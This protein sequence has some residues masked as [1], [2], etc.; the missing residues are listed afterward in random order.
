M[1]SESYGYCNYI[2]AICN[3]MTIATYR[4][5]H[6]HKMFYYHA[7]W[8]HSYVQYDHVDLRNMHMHTLFCNVWFP[9]NNLKYLRLSYLNDTLNLAKLI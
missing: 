7:S 4:Y 2:A 6:D 5:E 1:P 8:L 3:V 9:L